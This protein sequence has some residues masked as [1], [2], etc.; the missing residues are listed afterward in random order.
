M[1]ASNPSSVF[2]P[3]GPVLVTQPTTKAD[4]E[5]PQDAPKHHPVFVEFKLSRPSAEHFGCLCPHCGG[6]LHGTISKA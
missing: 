5:K 6:K 1:D 4:P 3:Q 2:A